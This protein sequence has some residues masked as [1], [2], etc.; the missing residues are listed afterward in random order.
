MKYL[1]MKKLVLLSVLIITN[2]ITTQWQTN[3]VA[4]C[5]TNSNSG[6][7]MLPQIASDGE[8]GAFVC[9]KD[10]RSGL[11]YYIYMQH[12]L[13]D[14]SMQFPHNGIPICDATNTQQF[15]RMISDG[16]GGAFAAWED[17]RD[18]T[19]LYVYAQRISATGEKLWG[20]QGIKV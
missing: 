8:G 11:D 10:A 5:D 15:P 20:V 9:W 6:F 12:I 19:N 1:F 18:G 13:S 2:T 16:K 4:V 14:G 7:Y 17:G 3:G